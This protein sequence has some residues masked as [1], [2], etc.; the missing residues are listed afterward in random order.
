[1]PIILGTALNLFTKGST[2]FVPPLFVLVLQET[3]TISPA[4]PLYLYQY[5]ENAI[6]AID[7]R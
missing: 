5:F 2:A 7:M 1:M 4:L 3:T 6:D